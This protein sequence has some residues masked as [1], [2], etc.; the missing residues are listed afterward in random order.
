MSIAN[1]TR[2]FEQRF[3]AKAERFIWHHPLLGSISIFVGMPL[4]VL[5]CV[6]SV[7]SALNDR[8]QHF[9]RDCPL[10]DGRAF[11]AEGGEDLL[12][13]LRPLPRTHN[14]LFSPVHQI[15]RQILN[16]SL[17]AQ[18]DTADCQRNKTRRHQNDSDRHG[19]KT[20]NTC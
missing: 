10:D 13:L 1:A 17:V 14:G 9:I 18:P 12:F 19:N 6:C 16:S 15:Q 11:G 2:R 20:Q 4:L 7:K 5:A 3:D 8:I